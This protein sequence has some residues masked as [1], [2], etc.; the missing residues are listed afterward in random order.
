MSEKTAAVDIAMALIAAIE[1]KDHAAVAAT[2]ADNVSKI[3]PYSPDNSGRPGAIFVGKE[4]VL[5]YYEAVFFKF[6]S[7][8]WKDCEWTPSADG[9]RAFLQARGEIVVTHSK[10]LYRNIY[11][12]RYDVEGGRIVR[13]LEYA[14]PAM[15]E[16][17][18][19]KP[20]PVEIKAVERAR[21]G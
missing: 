16:D 8:A 14:N 18:G 10:A 3:F 21:S 1:R 4:E 20:A 5:A 9:K 13:M 2:L 7:L 19:I 11:V 12:N 6:D 17:L 15:Y